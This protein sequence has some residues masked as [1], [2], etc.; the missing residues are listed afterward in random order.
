VKKGCEMKR[1][2]VLALLSV[3]AMLGGTGQATG[4]DE[5]NLLEDG[6]S[7]EVGVDGFSFNDYYLISH[8][9]REIAP[10]F[11]DTTA[12]HGRYS[13]RLDNSLGDK[14][15]IAF[16]PIRVPETT[17]VTVSGYVKG[18]GRARVQ[19]MRFRY[20]A[21]SRLDVDLT[22]DWQRFSFPG[23][24]KSDEVYYLWILPTVDTKRIWL[25]ALQIEQGGLGAFRPKPL[26]LSVAT[27]AFCN[28]YW[29]GDDCALVVRLYAEEPADAIPV[30]VR[31]LD[32]FRDEV[33][34]KSV[35]VAMQGR[36][37]ATATIPLFRGDRRG[38]YKVI[39]EA[40]HGGS[41]EKEVFQFGV[42]REVAEPDPFFG[43]QVKHIFNDDAERRFSDN[44]EQRELVYANVDLTY[45][46]ELMRR[47]GAPSL[48]CFR[49][50]EYGKIEKP[51]GEYVFRDAFLDLQRQAGL[52]SPLVILSGT[53]PEWDADPELSFERG[54]RTIHIPR[55]AEWRDYVRT[56][57][58]HY[59]GK[60]RYYEVVNEPE[61]I[62]KQVPVYV[63]Y[64]KAAH[65]VIRQEDLDA[66]IVA[67]SYSGRRPFEWI[68]EFCQAGGHRWVDIWA[69]HYAGRKLPEFGM[70]GATP[71]WDLIRRYR[72]ILVQHNGGKDKP[73]WN[74]EGGSF[75]WMPEYDHWPRPED[76][77][78]QWVGGEHHEVR[79]EPLAAAYAAR[80]Q[81]IEK[82][83][84]VDRLYSFELGF[85]YSQNASRARDVWS[86]YTNYDGSPSPPLVAYNAVADVFAGAKPVALLPL[87]HNVVVTVF[88]RDGR[89]VAATW[90]GAPMGEI[91]GFER[92]DRPV[93]A[94][95][96]LPSAD[97]S[98]MDMLGHPL[99][100][101]P[102]GRGVRLAQTAFPIYLTSALAP[103]EV[104]EAFRAAR[105]ALGPQ[106]EI[107]ATAEELMAVMRYSAAIEV[108]KERLRAEPA[109]AQ[110]WGR[111]GTCYLS[112]Q[113]SD[114]A[115]ASF[116]KALELAPDS[117]EANAGL[118]ACIRDG[119]N[120]G[121]YDWNWAEGMA[122]AAEYMGRAVEGR[123]DDLVLRHDYW[124]L[125]KSSMQ[126]V[127]GNAAKALEQVQAA[128]RLDP[129]ARNF[130][131]Q[132]MI[133]S[134]E[135]IQERVERDRRGAGR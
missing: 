10:V 29:T 97:T 35:Q 109:D 92:Y 17:D 93:A 88:E 34:S 87:E 13:L 78:H 12:V 28:T 103:S 8:H 123:P 112:L 30:T 15:V 37:H 40:E 39:V 32:V 125:L 51:S 24:I 94:D 131:T 57:V 7:F 20:T 128:R 56:I 22:G 132:R 23:Q 50:A 102:S 110:A 2:S 18:E 95:V 129:Q 11:D 33:L 113:Q 49:T 43:F 44:N 133:A 82:A 134:R 42:L 79:N 96:A 130:R 98:L 90:K 21:T 31:V 41:L 58:R 72:D 4:Q 16:R 115:E 81:L 27:T 25:D 69:I 1:T 47:A 36:R 126:N 83:S 76:Q 117:V 6:A 101:E 107:G 91:S 104:V 114:E 74:T 86:M 75:Y 61:T 77:V 64:L 3:F 100:V 119:T 26:E 14:I 135:Q 19:L 62:F 68:E 70:D 84:G 106:P 99:E 55:L 65:D 120:A 111:M 66:L 46:N 45:V 85:Y 54:S 105:L 63:K 48:R 118:A 71:T 116:R 122:R 89:T 59:R 9:G 121:R 80:L 52:S 60:V 73:L 5:R 38:H 53:C 127:P 124:Y 67:P 108:L